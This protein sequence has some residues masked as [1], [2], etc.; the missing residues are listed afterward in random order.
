MS[1]KTQLQTN[2][3]NLDAL[4]TRVNAAKNIAASLPSAGGSEDLEAVISEQE[5]LIAELSAAVDGKASG[6]S[7]GRAETSYIRISY[8]NEYVYP[9]FVSY[10]AI[11]ENGNVCGRVK[12]AGD[13][14]LINDFEV[15]IIDAL[16]G[17]SITLCMS[18]AVEVDASGVT[19]LYGYQG[20]LTFQVND[21]ECVINLYQL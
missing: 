1:N 5:A 6:G 17:T 11:D 8:P 2:N 7:G 21:A 10:T 12:A 14:Y 15:F 16:R 20:T 4:I 18:D 9:Y 13:N 19:Y 3:T